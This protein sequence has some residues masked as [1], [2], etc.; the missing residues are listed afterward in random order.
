MARIFIEF[1]NADNGEMEWRPFS[2]E[3]IDWLMEKEIIDTDSLGY[4]MDDQKAFDEALIRATQKGGVFSY[5]DIIKT[6]LSLTDKE[7]RIK[8]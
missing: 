1:L 2:P 3:D 5:S 7:I 8:A 4:A 6:Y